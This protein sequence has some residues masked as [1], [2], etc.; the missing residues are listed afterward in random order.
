MNLLEVLLQAKKL[1]KSLAVDIATKATASKKAFGSL[2]GAVHSD[3]QV[4]ASRAAWCFSLAA[5]IKREWADDSQGELV[6]LL[7]LENPSD[8]LLRNLLRVLRSC[9]LNPTYYEPLSF[10]CFNYLEDL[11]QS[12]AIKAFALHILGKIC[13]GAPELKGPLIEIIQ[14][15]FMDEGKKTSAGLRSAALRVYQQGKD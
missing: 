5:E 11:G 15:Y 12:I 2:L 9:H 13:Q 6:E 10:Y 14:F 3:N 8:M 1:D 4:L 7:A